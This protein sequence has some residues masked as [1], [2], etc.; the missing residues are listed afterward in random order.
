MYKIGKM[1]TKARAH[2]DGNGVVIFYS[3]NSGLAM[4]TV[5]SRLKPPRHFSAAHPLQDL[6]ISFVIE[7]IASFIT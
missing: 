1:R 7:A 2:A 4:M 5:P 6:A 3:V